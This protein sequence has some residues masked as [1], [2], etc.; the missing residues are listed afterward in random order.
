[1]SPGEEFK[2]PD[3]KLGLE[4]VEKTLKPLARSIIATARFLGKLVS[5]LQSLSLFPALAPNKPVLLSIGS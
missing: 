4:K 2:V 3:H 1:M 5:F